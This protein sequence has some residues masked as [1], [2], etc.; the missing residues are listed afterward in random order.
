MPGWTDMGRGYGPPRGWWEK[1][2]IDAGR[3]RIGKDDDIRPIGYHERSMIYFECR[4]CRWRFQI[5]DHS[6]YFSTSTSDEMVW[7]HWAAKV[8]EHDNECR[9]HETRLKN[10]SMLQQ[11]Q[12]YLSVDPAQTWTGATKKLSKAFTD[13]GRKAL[14]LDTKK[15]PIEWLDGELDRVRR[16]AGLKQK[17]DG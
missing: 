2:G 15:T 7:D 6:M 10:M 3:W 9:Q 4:M 14:G 11:P 16:K 12:V 8:A 13:A 1:R 17:G 5:A